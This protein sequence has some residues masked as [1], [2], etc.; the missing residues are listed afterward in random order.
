MDKFLNEMKEAELVGE[1]L[2]V[3]DTTDIL[4]FTIPNTEILL[5]P[6]IRVNVFTECFYRKKNMSFPQENF[7]PKKRFSLDAGA[8]NKTIKK[9]PQRDIWL[10][11]FVG[12]ERFKMKDGE[13]YESWLE[14]FAECAP[15]K[16]LY[17]DASEGPYFTSPKSNYSMCRFTPLLMLR[18]H[19]AQDVPVTS[20]TPVVVN[21]ILFIRERIKNK[22]HLDLEN[23]FYEK[24]ATTLLCFC[25]KYV[26]NN[27]IYD[28]ILEKT[29][30]K[31]YIGTCLCYGY[32]GDIIY[33]FRKN[34]IQTIELQH[35]VFTKNNYIYRWAKCLQEEKIFQNNFPE[36]H[37]S[38]GTEIDKR[39]DSMVRHVLIGNP[40]LAHASK[41]Y[42]NSTGEAILFDNSA[43]LDIQLPWIKAVAEAFPDREVIVRPHPRWSSAFKESQTMQLSGIS[44]DFEDDIYKALARS[45]VVIGAI[46]AF[47]TVLYE[48]AA[49]GKVAFGHEHSVGLVESQHFIA[50][51]SPEDLVKKI[52]LQEKRSDHN[53]YNFFEL[54]WE[55][56]YKDFLA[57]HGVL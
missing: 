13:L 21:F 46:S 33:K 8:I 25:Q 30:P 11:S 35:G 39:I 20:F 40:W 16:T 29:R 56:N 45:R 32:W 6:I 36:Y 2:S 12:S 15:E 44:V 9:M 18:N 31:I 57:N 41:S 26:I 22:L 1:I 47:S 10:Y 27:V 43:D 52:H 24:M 54:S 28:K 7:Y 4:N 17:L 38:F 5:W 51:S 37:F 23:V 48:A 42:A 19:M 50:Y 49:F 34:N 14:P 55:K 53:N 3:E